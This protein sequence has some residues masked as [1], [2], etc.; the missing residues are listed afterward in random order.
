MCGIAGF[1]VFDSIKNNADNILSEMCRVISHRGPDDEGHFVDQSVALSMRRL[2]II[3]LEAGHQPIHNEDNTIWVVFNGE[4]Y[5][6]VEL[7][8]ELRARGHNFYTDSDSEVIVHAYEEYG[9]SFVDKLIG[10]FGIALWDSKKQE[11]VLIRD[12]VG[13][14]PLYYSF[15]GKELVFGSEIKSILEHPDI[16]AEIN[17]D[18]IDEYFTFGYVC[19]PNTMYKNIYKLPA[20]HIARF[21]KDGFEISKYWD[22]DGTDSNISNIDEAVEE[23]DQLLDDSIRLR[24]RSDVPFGAFLSGGIDSSLVVAKMAKQIPGSVKTF[25]IAF[26]EDQ[27]NE[28][29]YARK[30]ADYLGTDHQELTVSASATDIVED[31]VWHFDEPFGDSSSVP[32]YYVSKLA[33]EHV[34]MSLSGDGGDE[35]FAGYSRYDKYL[36]LQKYKKI[37]APIRNFVFSSLSRVYGNNIKGN[38]YKWYKERLS[39]NDFDMYLMG[40]ALTK[41]TIKDVM[42]SGREGLGKNNNLNYP[43]FEKYRFDSFSDLSQILKLDFKTYLPEDILN[44]VDRMSMANS[45]EARVPML[46]HRFVELAYKIDNSLKYKNGN[47]KIVLK[48]LLSKYVPDELFE[49]PKKGFSIPVSDWINNDM[50]EMVDDVLNSE[51]MRGDQFF[52]M[53]GVLKTLNDHRKGINNNSEPIWLLLN[54]AMWKQ[55]FNLH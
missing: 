28:S 5:N 35:L 52:N 3:D 36:Q 51:V 24:L 13:I 21:N 10:M 8:R 39:A 47:A 54:Y 29:K 48:K 19:S 33:S 6:F 16:I 31:L 46:D 27:F 30:V 23:M 25:T 55:K 17:S 2:S 4:I 38:K 12:R 15:S 49:R 11:L 26:N 20:G 32:T 18:V 7:R 9:L 14:K 40:I 41:S 50:K 42:Y 1:A 45:L 53:D 34:K 43:G 37:P 22:I 44:K